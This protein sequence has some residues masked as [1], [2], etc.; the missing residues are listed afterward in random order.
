MDT[1][2]D[3]A[4][5]SLKEALVSAPVMRAPDWNR[6][7][8][9][10]TD[11]SQLAVGGIL[12]QI[13]DS[14]DEYV[15]SYFSKRLTPAEENYSANDRELLGLVKFLQR[16]RCYLEG[17]EF[18]VLTDNQVLRYFFSKLNLSRREANWLE[19][20]GQFGITKLTLVKGRVHVLGDSPSRA[21]QEL[22]ASVTFNNVTMTIPG[23]ELPE[24]FIQNY[25]R[26]PTF[27]DIYNCLKGDGNVGKVKQSRTQRLLPR[28]SLRNELLTYDGMICV[29]RK[30]VRDILFMA[31][32]NKAAGHFGYSKTLSRLERFHWKHKSSDVF[33]YCKGCTVCQQCKDGRKKPFGDPQP[34]ELPDRRWGSVSMDFVTHLPKTD[35][36][37]DCITTF[38]DRFSKRIRLVPSKGTDSAEEVANCF[39]DHIF[40]IH[41]LPDS[42]V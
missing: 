4:F 32:D 30:N 12:T 27:G 13:D 37:F 23:L 19:F 33:K 26:D 22:N 18:E 24:N 40:R 5:L 36:G 41:G 25:E 8:R 11:A 10:H 2:C 7:F 29:P 20:L 1:R 35:A 14:G 28:F 38:V 42:I 16:F 34:L 6:P 21:P 39:F 31:H 15:I 9:C 3:A 17:S